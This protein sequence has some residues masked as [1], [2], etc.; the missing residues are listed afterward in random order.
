MPRFERQMP[1]AEEFFQRASVA[2][3]STAAANLLASQV[4]DSAQMFEHRITRGRWKPRGARI[5]VRGSFDSVEFS[6]QLGND[7]WEYLGQVCSLSRI[8]REIVEFDRA[9]PLHDQSVITENDRAQILFEFVLARL[10]CEDAKYGL[11]CRVAKEI[12]PLVLAQGGESEEAPQR[13][14]DV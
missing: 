6:M 4:S 13:R 10:P 8:G 12:L 2:P 11:P 1:S 5:H 14:G 7:L 9:V 3:C